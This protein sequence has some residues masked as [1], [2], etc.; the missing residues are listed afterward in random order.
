MSSPS[1]LVLL[2]LLMSFS[3]LLCQEV[4]SSRGL[5]RSGGV[6]LLR[7]YHWKTCCYGRWHYRSGAVVARF[8]QHCLQLMCLEGHI[9]PH[10]LGCPGETGCC[11]WGS[12]M[13]SNGARLPDMCVVMECQ[14][15]KWVDLGL[16]NKECGQCIVYDDPHFITFDH[17]YYDFHGTCNYSLVQTHSSSFHPYTAVYASF[18]PCWSASCLGVVVFRDNPHTVLSINVADVFRYRLCRHRLD[19][20]APPSLGGSGGGVWGLCGVYNGNKGDD[21]TARHGTTYPL[22]RYPLA[23]PISWKADDEGPHTHCWYRSEQGVMSSSGRQYDTAPRPCQHE[24]TEEERTDIWERVLE[25]CQQT[26]SPLLPKETQ[27]QHYIQSCAVDLCA[28]RQHNEG[29]HNEEEEK[30]WLEV[31]RDLV[32]EANM[33]HKAR[34]GERT[35]WKRDAGTPSQT[36]TESSSSAS[37]K[38]SHSILPSTRAQ[39]RDGTSSDTNTDTSSSNYSQS[40]PPFSGVE[41]DGTFSHTTDTSSSNYSQSVPPF[42]GLERDGTSSHLT[43]SSSGDYSQSAIPLRIQKKRDDVRPTTSQTTASS[44]SVDISHYFVSLRVEA[45]DGTSHMTH[46]SSLEYS[47]E[48]IIPLRVQERDGTSSHTTYPSSSNYSQSIPPFSGLERDGTSSH[49]TDTSSSNYSQSIPPFSGLERDGTSSHTTDPSSVD[50]S[51]SVYPLR[52]QK[53]DDISS[54]NTD[55]SSSDYSQSVQPLRGWNFYK[56]D[57]TTPKRCTNKR[58]VMGRE[59]TRRTTF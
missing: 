16:I 17:H 52:V 44:S 37:P 28:L 58:E 45:R 7:H 3:L 23:F 54:H 1:S 53:R 56:V 40:V 25:V 13:Y 26:L 50:Y 19:I 51:Q 57:I 48:S 21:F 38:F 8:P 14:K 46:S 22:S 9:V 18:V 27:L 2:L 24:G 39:N 32:C 11:V 31:L 34:E 29:G 42:S 6:S 33:I 47:S 35:S 36:N 30:E 12:K 49:N 59:S 41:R 10:Y 55:S 20:W 5:L 4:E 43:H 15:G